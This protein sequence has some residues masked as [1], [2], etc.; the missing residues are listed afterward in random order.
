MFRRGAKKD[1]DTIGKKKGSAA[2]DLVIGGPSNFAVGSHG[3]VDKSTGEV[4]VCI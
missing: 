2:E 3:E 1:K 4:K